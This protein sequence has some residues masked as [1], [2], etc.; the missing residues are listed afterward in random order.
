MKVFEREQLNQTGEVPIDLKETAKIKEQELENPFHDDQKQREV[1]NTEQVWEYHRQAKEYEK[2]GMPFSR[3]MEMVVGKAESLHLK[4][5]TGAEVQIGPLAA[6]TDVGK[7]TEN[8]L[9]KN[10]RKSASRPDSFESGVEQ[11]TD[12]ETVLRFV[13]D[14]IAR[15]PERLVALDIRDW[16]DLTP[17]QGVLL[18]AEIVNDSMS[19]SHESLNDATLSEQLDDKGVGQLLHDGKGVCRHYAA[20]NKTVF[21]AIKHSQHSDSLAGTEIRYVSV[22]RDSRE[23][24]SIES[25]SFDVQHH[26][27]NLVAVA[28]GERGM[29]LSVI[30]PTWADADGPQSGRE[31]LYDQKW[32]RS[33]D[34]F[35]TRTGVAVDH[36]VASGLLDMTSPENHSLLNKWLDREKQSPTAILNFLAINFFKKIGPERYT[37]RKERDEVIIQLIEYLESARPSWENANLQI[38]ALLLESEA[39]RDLIWTDDVMARKRDAVWSELESRSATG[40]FDA[41][42]LARDPALR[43]LFLWKTYD[44]S[45]KGYE[46]SYEQ[47][48]GLNF[49]PLNALIRITEAMKAYIKDEGSHESFVLDQRLTKRM[50]SIKADMFKKLESFISEVDQ[51]LTQKDARSDVIKSFLDIESDDDRTKM[52]EQFAKSYSDSLALFQ[53]GESDE[54]KLLSLREKVKTIIQELRDRWSEFEDIIT[55]EREKPPFI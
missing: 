8:E 7:S 45:E 16:K 25:T 47:R 53:L 10:F 46:P 3:A 42:Y 33:L 36:L 54:K 49:A 1:I 50:E 2:L 44:I 11:R 30:D 38:V 40:R 34:K 4:T 5:E 51:F 24:T 19:Y 15:N 32:Q 41:E 35:Y 20:V 23:P 21:D 26:A 48:N 12:S 27:F 17:W 52:M 39:Y 22:G 37:N 9:I 14:W 13:E 6:I 29:Y 18:A 55:A 31:G 43:G 28:L